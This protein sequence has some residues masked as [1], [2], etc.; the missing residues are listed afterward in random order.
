LNNSTVPHMFTDVTY[1]SYSLHDRVLSND[2]CN[3]TGNSSD[4]IDLFRQQAQEQ[5]ANILFYCGLFGG[6]PAIF[7]TNW[8]GVNCR[9][10]GRKTLLVFSLFSMV[11]RNLMFLM[12]AIYPLLPDYLFFINSFIDGLCGGNQLYFLV[13]YCYI[14]DVT[15]Y[16]TRSY[17]LTLIN[18]MSSIM[19]IFVSYGT[20]YVIKFFGFVWVFGVSLGFHLIALLYAIIFVPEPLGSLRTMTLRTRI[21][22][23]STKRILNSFKVFTRTI[24]P[25]QT[26]QHTDG[27]ESFLDS[28]EV[29]ITTKRRQRAI[30]ILLVSANVVYI[31][32]SA[33][34]A[35]IFT[36]F[37]MNAPLCWDSIYISVF[38]VYSTVTSLVCSLIVSRYLRVNEIAICIVSI[39]TNMVSSVM[40]GFT[41]DLVGVY[42]G[43]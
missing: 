26:T 16:K 19:F 7:S 43:K 15:P 30:L 20:G 18:Y 13:L 31:F 33:G 3:S 2:M 14:A 28:N 9:K 11:V 12:Q 10:L 35:S 39:L 25:V 21:R 17:R 4:I 34:I 27:P 29:R 5:S 8:L 40:Y 32:G 1:Q 22:S 36:L 37:L 23:C 42:I 6:L 41:K 38:N 24:H